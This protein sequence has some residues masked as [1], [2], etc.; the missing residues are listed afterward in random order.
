ML[1]TVDYDFDLNEANNSGFAHAIG[2]AR[3]GLKGLKDP[4]AAPLTG[5]TLAAMLSFDLQ[6][7]VR[8]I[9][10]AWCKGKSG[11]S[12][13]GP[14]DIAPADWV[15][16]TVEDCAGL[17][18]F[19]YQGEEE[20]IKSKTGMFAAMVLA[21][22][23]D[24]MYDIGSS[25]RMSSVMYAAAAGVAK[26]DDLHCIF[27]RT[28]LD[29][30]ARRVSQLRDDKTPLYGDSALLVTAAWAP[31]NRRYRTWERVVKYHR[32]LTR[33]SHAR[34]KLVLEN[35]A[36]ELVLDNLNIETGTAEQLWKKNLNR[37]SLAHVQP[38]KTESYTTVP[39]TDA[40]SSSWKS[41]L[42]AP[43]VPAPPLCTSC[44]RKLN[45]IPATTPAA[46]SS[47]IPLGPEIINSDAVAA[48]ARIALAGRWAMTPECCAKCSAQ[49]G[50]W[51]DRAAYIVLIGLMQTEPVMPSAKWLLQC[52]AVWCTISSPIFVA[53]ILSGF[54]LLGEFKYEE[55]AMGSRDVVGC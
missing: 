23:H 33:S 6:K 18:P 10:Q 29:Q 36:T 45:A 43:G 42:H 40:S 17:C 8:N 7:E 41:V 52:Y 9:Q 30:I 14:A 24:L 3:K 26:D 46:I 38:R 20:Y 31:F 55:G 50:R 15:C 32:Q 25:N 48:A 51:A 47:S 12:N 5:A 19:G 35:S 27:V 11:A 28:I 16:G 54:D 49:I 53:T 21:N 37:G 13:L 34:A 39:A 4:R 2:A 44:E 22:T 1:S